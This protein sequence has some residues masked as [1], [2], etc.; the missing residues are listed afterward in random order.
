MYSNQY[1]TTILSCCRKRLKSQ[2]KVLNF[3]H[4]NLALAL[5]IAYIVF[6]AGIERA[7]GNDVGPSTFL[8]N[9]MAC[10]AKAAN[11]VAFQ[12]QAACTSVAVLLFYFFLASFFWMLCEG[13]MLYFMV[14]MVFS[15]LVKK[16]WFFFF[17]GWCE[18]P[19]DSFSWIC[20]YVCA[21][22]SDN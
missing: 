10:C 4:L 1:I 11:C 12:I 21:I 3:I 19:T 17:L 18:L 9:R 8:M 20:V 15:R 16:W 13:I 14:V 7:V 2:T 22:H 5:L 6:V